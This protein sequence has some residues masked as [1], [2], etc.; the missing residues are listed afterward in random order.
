[1]EEKLYE[2]K[3]AII[4]RITKAVSDTSAKILPAD[5][6]T[7]AIIVL[8]LSIQKGDEKYADLIAKF[9]TQINTDI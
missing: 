2:V 8:L 3:V 1:M 6:K 4:D 7:L 9:I 5:L